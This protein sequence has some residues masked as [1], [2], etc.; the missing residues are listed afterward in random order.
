[1]VSTKSRPY[2]S[3]YRLLFVAWTTLRERS[4]APATLLLGTRGSGCLVSVLR[5]LDDDPVTSGER[6]QLHLRRAV[7]ARRVAYGAEIRPHRPHPAP[8]APRR[9]ARRPI[10]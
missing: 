5:A 6:G 8:C 9:T 1:M 3:P 7:V 10:C 2:G 4:G